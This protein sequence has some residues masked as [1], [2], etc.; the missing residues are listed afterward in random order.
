MENA[1]PVQSILG[2]GNHGYLSLVITPAR[3][4]QVMGHIFIPPP[5]PGP[6]PIIPRLFMTAAEIRH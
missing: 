2:G 4:Q 5:N 1:A 3:Y 6:V